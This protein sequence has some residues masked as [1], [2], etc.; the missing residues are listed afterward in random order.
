MGATKKDGNTFVDLWHLTLYLIKLSRPRFWLYLAGPVLLALV[1]SANSIAELIDPFNIVYFLYFLIPANI[2]LYGVN[3]I[4]D[5]E[6]DEVNP[7]KTGREAVFRGS[8][9]TKAVIIISGVIGLAFLPYFAT[10]PKIA[11][12]AF[13]F[14]AVEYSA[15]PLR[16]K[17][18]P[19]LDSVSNGLYVLPGIAVYLALN[20]GV[21]PTGF[22]IGGW[23]WTMA[24]HTF[25]AVPDI[26][27]DREAGISTTATILG[28]QKTLIYCFIFWLFASLSIAT[29]SKTAALVTGIYPVLVI[30]IMIKEPDIDQVYWW[31]P[32]I[33]GLLGMVLT[34]PGIWRLVY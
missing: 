33:N 11:L 22:I 8:T 31:Y 17:T 3:D 7:K 19:I 18:T 13:Y 23:F 32:Y 9:V 12:M 2:F 4:F 29:T 24:M 26:E 20:T 5:A 34:L 6:I 15:P 16:F 28:K 21:I 27:P 14:L 1:Y 25:S 10:V 30:F